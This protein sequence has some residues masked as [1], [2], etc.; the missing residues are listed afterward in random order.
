MISISCPICP[1]QTPSVIRFH[2][3]LPKREFAFVARKTPECAHFQINQ[4]SGC[5]LVFASPILPFEKIH[6]LYAESSYIDEPQV[7]NMA[8][9]YEAEFRKFIP[10]LQ[11]KERALEIGSSSGF[12]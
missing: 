6:T 5:G 7:G 11:G 1:P 2:E 4:C 10:L 9:D 3:R 12:F 8:N